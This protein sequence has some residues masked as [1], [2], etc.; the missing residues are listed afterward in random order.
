MQY[1]SNPI[2]ITLPP[3]SIHHHPCAPEFPNKSKVY[4][5]KFQHQ[6]HFFPSHKHHI[7]ITALARICQKLPRLTIFLH[8][9][10]SASWSTSYDFINSKDHLSSL[11][12]NDSQI[13][14]SDMSPTFQDKVNV[15]Q[16]NRKQKG[17]MVVR[18]KYTVIL[19][20][21]MRHFMLYPKITVI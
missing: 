11:T 7:N 6:N 8:S 9:V 5:T 13:P 20:I 21:S 4:L 10:F 1:T 18:N 2:H 12:L 19:E 14:R 3:T 16:P 15:R 17:S